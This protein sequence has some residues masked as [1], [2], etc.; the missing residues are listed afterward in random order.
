MYVEYADRHFTVL[1]FP[2]NQFGGQEP[3]DNTDVEQFAH[4]KGA[5]FPMFSKVDVNDSNGNEDPV[6]TFLKQSGGGDIGWNFEKFLVGR[7]GQVVKRYASA[8][9][10]HDMVQDILEALEV[11]DE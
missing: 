2:C 7:D 6:F 10:P 4:S 11:K 5:T 1:A 9:A 3:G 8:V